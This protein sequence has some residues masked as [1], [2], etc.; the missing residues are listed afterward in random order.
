MKYALKIRKGDWGMFVFGKTL[1]VRR[2]CCVLLFALV[3]AH[4]AVLPCAAAQAAPQVTLKFAGQ[5]PAD[6]TATKFMNDIAKQ[7]AEKTNGR[8]EIR[9]FPANQLGDYTLVF[10]ELIRGTIDLAGVSI[11]SQFD[12]RM[13][14][15]YIN[16]FVR[17]YED[18]KKIFAPTGWL[19]GKMDELN[20]ALGVKLLGFYVEGFIG[21][22]SVKPVKDPLDPNVPKGVLVRIPNMDVYKLAAEAMGYRTVTIP[23]ADVYQSMQTGVCEGVNGYPIAS[24]YTT[25]GDVIK[26]WYNTNYSVECLNYMMSD[27]VWEKLSPEDQKVLQDAFTD[28]TMK[29]I[30]NAKAEDER[31]LELMRKKGIQ[32]FTYTD[33][34]L[35]PL[36]EACAS[37]WPGLEGKMTKEL[38]DEFRK[39]LAPK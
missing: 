26:Y 23:Y 12:P 16:G 5:S 35:K 30:D 39:E 9:V 37:S 31:H 18:A 1:S 22:G 28:A 34:E 15:V 24:A 38:M 4:I 11:P 10:E 33:A 13:E 3:S 29:S 17:G 7:V 19:F 32:V 27:M 8:I 14:L 20:R 6:H 25:L 36:A 2:L 21:T